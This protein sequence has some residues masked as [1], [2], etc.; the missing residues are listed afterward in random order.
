MDTLYAY[1]RWLIFKM[2]LGLWVK[3]NLLL[4]FKFYV[5]DGEV[6]ITL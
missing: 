5:W 2:S 3:I 1:K 4:D 6:L